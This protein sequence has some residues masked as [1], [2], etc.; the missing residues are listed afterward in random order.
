MKEKRS[1]QQRVPMTEDTKE[2]VDKLYQEYNIS[3]GDLVEWASYMVPP[4]A[5]Q[6]WKA[7][8]RKQS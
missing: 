7:D 2:R 8:Q 3:L 5:I 1:K 4:S 6:L